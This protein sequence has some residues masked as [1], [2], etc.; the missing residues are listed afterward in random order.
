[1]A[2]YISAASEKVK[3]ADVFLAPNHAMTNPVIV[4]VAAVA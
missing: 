4:N 1:M 3:R 2:I